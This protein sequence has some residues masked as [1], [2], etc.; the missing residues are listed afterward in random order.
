MVWSAVGS[1]GAAV[2]GGLFGRSEASRNRAFQERMSSTSYQRAV[3]DL[4]AAGLNPMLAYSQGGASTPGGSQAPTPDIGNPVSAQQAFRV[5]RETEKNLRE[6]RD[7]IRATTDKTAADAAVARETERLTA[8]EADKAEVTKRLYKEAGPYLDRVIEHILPKL[9]AAI[10]DP[11]AATNSAKNATK[12][13]V[14]AVLDQVE[15]S[16]GKAYEKSPL[17]KGVDFIRERYNLF[18]NYWRKKN[19]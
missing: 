2:G 8:A 9:D 11:S 1:I 18:K 16:A 19:D 5:Q 15:E 13:I 4:R 6:T 7:Q 12:E 17:K 3:K 10:Q 14:E